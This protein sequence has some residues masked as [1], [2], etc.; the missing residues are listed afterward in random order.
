MAGHIIVLAGLR[1]KRARLAGEIEA[2]D[3]AIR[4][5]REALATLDAVIRMF[6]PE[7]DPEL[8]AS[9]RPVSRR[10]MFF[11]H[12]EFTRLCAAA[13]REA[14]KPVKASYVATYALEAKGLGEADRRVRQR[15]VEQTRAALV[16]LAAKGLARK[17]MDWPDTWWE[18][19]IDD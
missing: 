13:L 10:C 7:S 9:I 18:L 16:R 1:D 14:G 4:K 12:G 11:R 17:I 5:Q 15:I 8:I 3:R 19:A 2:A 6:E